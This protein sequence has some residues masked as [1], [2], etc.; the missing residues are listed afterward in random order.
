VEST[1]ADVLILGELW[2]ER[3]YIKVNGWGW[4]R[5]SGRIDRRDACAGL[6]SWPDGRFQSGNEK[7]ADD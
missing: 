4:R 2:R 3:F 7:R 5:K 6:A 1:L